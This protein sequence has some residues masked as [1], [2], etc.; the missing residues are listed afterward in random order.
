MSER[1]MQKQ[2]RIALIAHD[3]MKMELVEWC[4]WNKEVL[5]SH[6]L[7]GTGTTSKLIAEHTGLPV[8]SYKSGP[9]GGDQQIGS[10]IAENDIDCLIFFFDP[11]EPVAHDTDVKALLRI[12]AVYDIPTATN[13]SS[14]DF[15]ISSRCMHEEYK[16]T[17][18]VEKGKAGVD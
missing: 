13:R 12:A 4:K 7:C 8:Y 10:R 18:N 9:L 1:I 17:L 11:L 14:A 6:F 15:L 5:K 16:Y 3:N 2:K